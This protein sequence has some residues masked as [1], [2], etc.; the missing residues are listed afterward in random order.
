MVSIIII[1]LLKLYFVYA[2][3]IVVHELFH[4]IS[5]VLLKKPLDGIYIGTKFMRVN[6]WKIHISPFIFYGYV[7]IEKELLE[8]MSRKEL[9]IF[10]LSGAL[11]NLV[12]G[13]ILLFFWPD[14]I[15][16]LIAFMLNIILVLASVLPFVIDD[17]DTDVL[18]SYLRKDYS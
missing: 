14:L 1:F 17:N 6:I 8:K 10:F 5:S 4:F 15:F 2:I 3:S 18:L 11:G 7:D 13:I 9:I 12:L 16:S